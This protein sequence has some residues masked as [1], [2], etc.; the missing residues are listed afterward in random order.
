EKI[1]GSAVDCGARRNTGQV[2]SHQDRIPRFVV[3]PRVDPDGRISAIVHGIEIEIGILRREGDT[4]AGDHGHTDGGRGGEVPGGV[5][6]DRGEGVARLRH[7][8]ENPGDRPLRDGHVGAMFLCV[9]VPPSVSGVVLVLKVGLEV[10]AVMATVGGVASLL[11]TVTLMLAEVVALPAASRALALSV[12][13][14]LGTVVVFQE[15]EYG[16]TRSSAPRLAPSSL[17]CTPTT[18]TLSAAAAETVTVFET[19]A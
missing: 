14:P 18:P 5:T 12:W 10:G 4:D 15:T 7:G 3:G 16:A 8:G 2:E 9:A 17:N 11:A 13:A 19:V 1:Q 6:G